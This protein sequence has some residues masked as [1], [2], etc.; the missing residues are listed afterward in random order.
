ML[1]VEQRARYRPDLGVAWLRLPVLIALAL[2]AAVGLAWGL[3]VAF[4]NGWY[5]IFLLPGL[6]GLALGGVLYALV[7]WSHCRNRWL[8]GTVG[9]L[10]GLA[11]Y[12]GYYELC[13]LDALPPA[14]AWRVDLL[15]TFIA[16]RMQTD[17][18]EDVGKPDNAQAPQKPFAA[19]NWFAFACELGMVVGA[20]AWFPWTRARRAYCRELGTWMRREKALLPT[21]S[22]QALQDA[23]ET[24][25]L[26]EFVAGTR[27]SGDAQSS[28]RFIVEHA[29]PAD[30]SPFDYPIYASLEAPPAT[31]PWHLLRS[32]RRTLFRQ[33][34]LQPAEVLALR[35]LFP[36]LTQLLAAEHEEL[37]DLPP[38]VTP[39]PISE[40]PVSQLA[41]ITP[42]PEPFRQRVRA[43]GYALW[44]NLVALTPGIYFFG[45]GALA[46]GGIWLAVER[47]APLGWAAAAAG[48]AGFLWGAYTGLFCLCVPENRWIERRLRR[49]IAQRPDALVDA[50][51]PESLFVSLIPR[52]SFAKIQLTMSTDLLLLKIDEPGRRLV[53]EGDCDRYR[54]PAGAIAVCEPECFFHPIDAQHRNHLWMARL[55][56]HVEEG[57][58]ELLLSVDTTR[59]TPMTNA[60]RRRTVESLCLRINGL[61]S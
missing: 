32:M 35:P 41:Q 8:A 50:R 24:G 11:G 46:A 7:G 13:L 52:E 51:D 1:T 58:R 20:G 44:T 56:V 37:R 57:L 27:A 5:F 12:L 16:F 36:H 14:L 33:V 22:M 61:G 60:G 18:A 39:T 53:M 30:G 34:A 28:C 9:I 21:S 42:V 31:R 2:V 6:G 54:I 15:P 43:R 26:A 23:L 45:G 38:G 19:L 55:M 25:S 49:E 17:V 40:A 10:A 48:A 59:W 47:S 29:A 4:L 3:K